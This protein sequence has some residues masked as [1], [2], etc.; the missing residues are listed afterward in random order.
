MPKYERLGTWLGARA[1]RRVS[2][3]FPQIEQ[4]I[5]NDLPPSA[6]T[7]RP[8]WG[9]EVH[10]GSRQCRAWLSNEWRVEAVDLGKEIVVFRRI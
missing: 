10:S 8:W 9:N 3:T 6:R 2:L 7:Y 5:C 1:N 4:I